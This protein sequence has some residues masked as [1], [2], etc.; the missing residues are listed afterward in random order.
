MFR[1][2]RQAT[3]GRVKD[4]SSTLARRVVA[5]AAA[6]T[7]VACG[8]A[9]FDGDEDRDA[10]PVAMRDAGPRRIRAVQGTRFAPVASAAGNEE[11]T[12][13]GRLIP[14]TVHGASSSGRHT[15]RGG[16]RAIGSRR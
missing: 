16:I 10:G 14:V 9:R 5:L 13:R 3:G 1:S 12:I 11:H 6:M 7:L 15:M 4:D 8:A 2:P